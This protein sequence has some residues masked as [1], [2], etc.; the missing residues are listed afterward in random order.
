MD[1]T[2][3]GNPVTLEIISRL[4]SARAGTRFNA[5]GIDDDGN[6]ANFV[7]VS[8][9]SNPNQRRSRICGASQLA[10]PQYRAGIFPSGICC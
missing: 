8:F 10:A 3:S 5:R 1:F 4:G 6:V 2:L 7:E 9:F